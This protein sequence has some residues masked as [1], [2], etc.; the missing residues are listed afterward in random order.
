LLRTELRYRGVVMS[1]DLAAAAPV[2]DQTS[3]DVAIAALRAGA[4]LLYLSGGPAEQEQ[5]SQ[6]VQEAV[7]R[8]RLG[9]ARIREALLRV[10]ALK[11]R[12]AAS[13]KPARSP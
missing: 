10:L 6:A 1:D 8:G 3:G 5:A 12:Y 2:L 7:R 11:R 13:A 4:D 9:R